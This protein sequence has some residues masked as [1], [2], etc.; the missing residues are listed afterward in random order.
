[1]VARR[2][3][4]RELRPRRCKGQAEEH[5]DHLST[6]RLCGFG[7]REGFPRISPGQGLPGPVHD[8]NAR[9]DP[10]LAFSQH[11]DLKGHTD[12]QKDG[13]QFINTKLCK[14]EKQ[15]L[16]RAAGPIATVQALAEGIEKD[17]GVLKHYPGLAQ[18]FLYVLQATTQA[19]FASRFSDTRASCKKSTS[20]RIRP[21]CG[22]STEAAGIRQPSMH[23]DT[24][25][26][27]QRRNH[28]K[29]KAQDRKKL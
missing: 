12:T 27:K 9:D 11:G 2:D 7:R 26:Q 15:I 24:E 8:E 10:V 29:Y 5:A 19:V 22:Y 21:S 6:L 28:L 13:G 17:V 1:M 14:K 20:F 16:K 23:P 18:R 3:Q 25:A 4:D